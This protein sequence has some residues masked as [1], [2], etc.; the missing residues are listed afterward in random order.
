MVT[1]KGEIQIIWFYLHL[2]GIGFTLLMR[3]V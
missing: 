1:I 3:V 2:V